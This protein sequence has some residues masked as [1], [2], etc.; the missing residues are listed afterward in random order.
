MAQKSALDQSIAL[1]GES[2]CGKTVLVSSFYGKAKEPNATSPYTVNAV[3]IGQ[4]NKL[5]QNYLRMRESALTPS[6]T[7]FDALSYDFS[8]ELRRKR[9]EGKDLPQ[10]V[11]RLTWH[12]YPGEWFEDD[13]SSAEEEL[14][15]V[16][17]FRSLLKSD[18]AFFLIDGQRLL[19]NAGEEERYL[20]SVITNFSNGLVT[21]REG[22]L[23]DGKKLDQFPRIWII[24]LSKADLLPEM[25]VVAFRDLVIEKAGGEIAELNE[26]LST[27]L[28]F[29]E[30]LSVGEDF[31]LLS[32][33]SFE[34]GSIEV[35]KR[36]G[37]DL[38]LPLASIL[39]LERHA[40]WASNKLLPGR[41]VETIFTP[42]NLKMAIVATALLGRKMR[43][44]K[45][46][47]VQTAMDVVLPGDIV[48]DA[49]NLVG[50]KLR[51][52]N[53][54]AVERHQHLTAMLTEFKIKLEEAEKSGIFLRSDR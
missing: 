2:G 9:G 10:N 42:K 19:D 27:F 25:N 33:A 53:A 13:L 52:A 11:I 48:E 23:E 21:L 5:H 51:E 47:F 6:Q 17:T 49:V 7:K 24:A 8:V 3:K 54:L 38:I 35:N 41:I 50:D 29:D 28:E 45:L 31:M 32:S 37:V 40:R 46:A 12:D 18:I 34:A 43:L 22:I 4:G 16:E 39:P 44:G 36:M 20:K 26:V 14:R 1:F 15:R 30:A